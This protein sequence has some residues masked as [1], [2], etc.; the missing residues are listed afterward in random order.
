MADKTT[1]QE[2]IKK[3]GE[4]VRK[5]KEEKADKDLVGL[6]NARE[7]LVLMTKFYHNFQD[8][9]ISGGYYSV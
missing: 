8:H 6:R 1:V 3:Q 4:I 9:A 5:L 2:E 7:C